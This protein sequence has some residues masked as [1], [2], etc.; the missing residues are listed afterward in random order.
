MVN[1]RPQ[2]LD[3]IH[4]HGHCRESVV[5][6]AEVRWAEDSTSRAFTLWLPA[7]TEYCRSSDTHLAPLLSVWSDWH[8]LNK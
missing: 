5:R 7:P 3:S 4:C 6:W 2:P 1:L 8:S